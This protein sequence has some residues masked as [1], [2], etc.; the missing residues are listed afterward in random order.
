M[1]RAWQNSAGA[2][3]EFS[4]FNANAKM[5]GQA[6]RLYKEAIDQGSIYIHGL[7]ANNAT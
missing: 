1:K 2:A 6:A 3:R 7:P 5:S 4:S